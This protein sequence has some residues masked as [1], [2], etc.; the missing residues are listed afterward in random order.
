MSYCITC[1]DLF[2]H[3]KQHFILFQYLILS[4]PLGAPWDFFITLYDRSVWID[5]SISL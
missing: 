5:M 2:A 3:W 4:S 1:L